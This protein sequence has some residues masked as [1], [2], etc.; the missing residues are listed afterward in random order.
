M[1]K[2]NLLKSICYL[3]TPLLLFNC[4]STNKTS[5][6][7]QDQ[8]RRNEQHFFWQD[9]NGNGQW[10]EMSDEGDWIAENGVL[11][12]FHNNGK[13][14][15]TEEYVNGDPNGELLAWNTQGKLILTS[16]LTDNRPCSGVK[17]F[18]ENGKPLA[19]Y[20][21]ENCN[22]K[23]AEIF[24]QQGKLIGLLNFTTEN[25]NLFASGYCMMADA[26]GIPRIIYKDG[27]RTIFNSKGEIVEKKE[28]LDIGIIYPDL[29]GTLFKY[30]FKKIHTSER[31]VLTPGCV[32]GDCENGLGTFE[33]L[34]GARYKGTFTNGLLNG[35]GEIYD[36]FGQLV[37]KGE[38]KQGSL[39]GYGEFTGSKL[40]YS[41]EFVDD[42]MHGKG[43][44]TFLNG[45]IYDGDFVNDLR[46]GKGVYFN[47]ETGEK[48]TNLWKKGIQID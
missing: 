22:P 3:I 44:M 48:T 43:K 36:I 34:F 20:T 23:K 11:T 19:E 47:Y 5:I 33:D 17:I 41:G 26:T 29:C 8:S 21:I 37:F 42:L 16:I 6:S 25:G 7:I 4:S 35:K 31:I 46:D 38:F 39:N 18:Y 30:Y 45:D 15:L 24:N 9:E 27:F 14:K 2:S 32:E 28:L 1:R 10:I 12:E 40:S 13:I